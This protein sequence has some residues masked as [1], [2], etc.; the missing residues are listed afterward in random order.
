[1]LAGFVDGWVD[2][3]SEPGGGTRVRAVL[4]SSRPPGWRPDL[5]VVPD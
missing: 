5:R 2:V 3:A 4:G 1:M